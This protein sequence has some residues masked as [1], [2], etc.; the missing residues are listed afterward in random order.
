M[1]STKEEAQMARTNA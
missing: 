1:Q